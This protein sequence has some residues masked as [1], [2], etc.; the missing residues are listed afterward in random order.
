MDKDFPEH[1]EAK[2]SD[3][4]GGIKLPS[5]VSNTQMFLVVS[6]DVQK[7]IASAVTAPV[8]YLRFALLNH[9]GRIASED[10]YIVNP[11]GAR[12]A[13]NQEQSKIIR[14]S[15]GGIIEVERFVLDPRKLSDAPTLFR[16]VEAPYEYI[17]SDSL[18][19]SIHDAGATNF[20]VKELE[21]AE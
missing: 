6:G 20:E 14:S 19:S 15:A 3:Q 21:Q 10:Y 4:Y 9:K 5:F 8:E 16:P 18:V 12:D 11:I 2:M 13:L 7:L 1:A 17:V